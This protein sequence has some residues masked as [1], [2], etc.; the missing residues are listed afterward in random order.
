M[1]EHEKVAHFRILVMA[2]EQVWYGSEEIDRP[3]FDE[4]RKDFER[5]YSTKDLKLDHAE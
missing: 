2:Y 3:F 4:L 5:F 1:S